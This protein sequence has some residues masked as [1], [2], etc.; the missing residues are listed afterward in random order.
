[1]TDVDESDA[2]FTLTGGVMRVHALGAEGGDAALVDDSDVALRAL[3]MFDTAI[4]AAGGHIA[5]DV[6]LLRPG[7]GLR[8]LRGGLDSTPEGGATGTGT[9]G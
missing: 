4:G 2:G 1:M 6:S 9:G 8:L 5:G 7:G 3:G